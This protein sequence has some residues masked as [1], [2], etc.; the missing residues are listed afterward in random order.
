MRLGSE[1]WVM[2]DKFCLGCIFVPGTFD[3]DAMTLR[4]VVACFDCTK[5]RALRRFTMV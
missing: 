2:V 1:E 5:S 3:I 4:W